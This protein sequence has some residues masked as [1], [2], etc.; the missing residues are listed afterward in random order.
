MGSTLII[1]IN[2][3]REHA[4]SA[5]GWTDE[6]TSAL[7]I[8]TPCNVKVEKFEYDC[9]A[10]NRWL[11]QGHNVKELVRRIQ[12]YG[13]RGWR[14]VAVAHS[15]GGAMVAAA[16]GMNI[17]MFSAHLISP[18]AYEKDFEGPILAGMIQRIHI[19]GSKNDAALK[20][21][22]WLDKLLKSPLLK[23]TGLGYGGLG[24]RG[25]EFAKQWPK[26]VEDHSIHTYDHSTWF[27][28]PQHLDHLVTSILI[29]D[30]R[31]MALLAEKPTT[32]LP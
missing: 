21:A 7:N 17:P 19:Y 18:A 23:W 6:C 32:K 24:L 1:L 5:R 9:H 27:A 29:N 14:I 26:V 25:G 22:T 30:Q 15:N 11:V 16:L 20:G 10:T 8:R 28:T 2:G 31:D 3:I 12:A 13:S 4:A